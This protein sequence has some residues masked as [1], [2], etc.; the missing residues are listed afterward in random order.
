MHIIAGKF[1]KQ[2]IQAPKGDSTR[3]TSSRLREALF[4]ILQDEIEGADFLDI[5]AGSGAIGIEALSRGAKSATFI[6]ADRNAYLTLTE[7]IKQLKITNGSVVFGDYRRNIQ[8]LSRRA[9]Q[10]HLIFADAP[11]SMQ[12]IQALIEEITKLDLLKLSGKLFIEN[13]TA[14]SMDLNLF[15]LTHL[16]SRKVGKT[17][18][19]QFQRDK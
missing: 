11:Y 1:Y 10:F 16:N 18:L 19:H 14:L 8:S 12:T 3:P 7:N 17:H 6:E 13:N 9:V 15:G 5:F 4:N 2:K